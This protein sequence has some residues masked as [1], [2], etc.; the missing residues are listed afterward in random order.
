MK[1]KFILALLALL[2]ILPAA[3]VFAEEIND[4]D[5]IVKDSKLVDNHDKNGIIPDSDSSANDAHEKERKYQYKSSIEH[6][7]SRSNIDLSEI[8]DGKDGN[9]STII[10]VDPDDTIIELDGNAR[11]ISD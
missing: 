1:I 8:E 4:E 5:Y 3:S 9:N 11:I 7:K 6:L 2:L 10:I